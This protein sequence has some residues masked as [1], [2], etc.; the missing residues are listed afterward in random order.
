M[1][2]QHIKIKVNYTIFKS[3]DFSLFAL[4]PSVYLY[5]CI[6]SLSSK[7]QNLS[8]VYYVWKKVLDCNFREKLPLSQKG[9]FSPQFE[10]KSSSALLSESFY[11]IHSFFSRK[12]SILSGHN[13]L[14]NDKSQFLGKNHTV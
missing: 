1:P 13:V 10:H 12:F 11:K 9:S 2:L 14:K 7:S 6:M 8:L 3:K 5:I 4:L